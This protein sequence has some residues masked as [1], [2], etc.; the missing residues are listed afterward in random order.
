[1]LIVL[2]NVEVI[3]ITTGKELSDIYLSGSVFFFTRFVCLCRKTYKSIEIG[4][5]LILLSVGK[6]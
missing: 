2:E 3:T 6:F 4:I 1:M 5:Y